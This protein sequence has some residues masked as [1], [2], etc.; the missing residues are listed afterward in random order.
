MQQRDERDRVRRELLLRRRPDARHEPRSRTQPHERR[1]DEEERRDAERPGVDRGLIRRRRQLRL[2]RQRA[3]QAGETEQDDEHQPDAP[4]RAERPPRRA[5]RQSPQPATREEVERRR[6]RTAGPQRGE[7]AGAPTRAPRGRRGT[8]RRP[9]RSGTST[10]ASSELSSVSDAFP[11]CPSRRRSRPSSSSLPAGVPASEAV[12]MRIAGAPEPRS[13]A[14][15]PYP[16]GS[17]SETSCVSPAGRRGAL[18]VSL[19]I[20]R[21]AV[22]DERRR[23]RVAVE[24]R[25]LEARPGGAREA[26]ERDHRGGAPGKWRA[27]RE[28]RRAQRAVRAAVRGQEDERVERRPRG[29]GRARRSR[30]DAQARRA[31]RFRSRCRSL[32]PSCR[33]CHDEQRSRS[34]RRACRGRRPR[35]S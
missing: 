16:N 35:G 21:V 9:S 12:A 14:C 8:P 23:R 7:G 30:R 13:G 10:A 28:A 11:S 1:R 17:A 24:P 25:E 3:G 2:G 31:R 29:L 27:G 19:A 5:E 33:C 34:S 15:S 6:A 18:P 22:C 26:V 32:P 20:R 4:A